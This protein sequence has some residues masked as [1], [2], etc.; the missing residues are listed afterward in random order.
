MTFNDP[1]LYQFLSKQDAIGWKACID[2]LLV[3]EWAALQA[4]HFEIIDLR[5]SGKRWAV[6]LIK[7]LWDTAC[8][9][10]WDHCNRVHDNETGVRAIELHWAF[11]DQFHLGS[12][13]VTVQ[14]RRLFQGGLQKV[15]GYSIEA[16][17]AW[18]DGLLRQE[19]GLRGNKRTAGAR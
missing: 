3:K 6:A 7:K 17:E 19:A 11:R 14:A 1:A 12:Q 4:S 8:W 2:G 18:G 9:D 10:M 15:L 5:R 16:K 13:G